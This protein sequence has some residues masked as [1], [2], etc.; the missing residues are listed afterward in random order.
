MFAQTHFS[1]TRLYGAVVFINILFA[2]WCATNFFINPDGVLYID[3]AKHIFS[4]TPQILSSQDIPSPFYSLL[5]HIV[6]TLTS[7]SW[8]NSAL[9]VNAVF[10]IFLSI[11]YL[12]IIQSLGANRHLLIIAAIVILTHPQLNYFR[13][14]IIR[15]IGFWA[16][17]YWGLYALIRYNQCSLMGYDCRSLSWVFIWYLTS[18]LAALFRVEGILLFLLGPAILLILN[19]LS[20]AERL[21]RF[22]L[23][24]GV[25][26]LFIISLLALSF[27]S[28]T[29]FLLR[30]KVIAL[31]TTWGNLLFTQ[32]FSDWKNQV[33]HLSQVLP[34][35]FHKDYYPV[36]FLSGLLAYFFIRFIV[37]LAPLHTLLFFYGFFHRKNSVFPGGASQSWKIIIYWF[38]LTLIIPFIFLLKANFVSGRYL[39]PA[40]LIALIVVPFAF[41]GFYKQYLARWFTQYPRVSWILSTLLIVVFLLQGLVSFGYSHAYI[42]EAGSWIE[43]HSAADATL[44]TNS[45]QLPFYADREGKIWNEDILQASIPQIIAANE[46]RHYDYLAVVVRGRKPEKHQTLLQSLSLKPVATFS[47]RRGDT[48]YLFYNPKKLSGPT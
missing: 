33:S 41:A 5:I 31:F 18:I 46:W 4:Q 29:L 37:M 11:G 30:L 26:L 24:Y 44:Y 20:H 25:S 6:H 34:V 27:F 8:L 12:K 48:L 42:K 14:F 40:C 2:L 19:P 1:L 38:F 16:M 10:F 36:F 7:F 32:L 21:K 28:P 47:N 17:M 45:A 22:S 23:F 15:D 35:F 9:C 13:T 39:F 3:I 43:S